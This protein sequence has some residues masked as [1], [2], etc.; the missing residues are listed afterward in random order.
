VHEG[1][2][3]EDIR[4]SVPWSTCPALGRGI[5]TTNGCGDADALQRSGHA[6]AG[7]PRLVIRQEHIARMQ[8]TMVDVR[9]RRQ[10]ERSRQLHRYAK[11]ISGRRRA[12]LTNRQVQRFGRDVILCEVRRHARDTGRQWDR[13]CGVIQ[14]GGDELIE[15]GNELMDAFGRQIQFEELDRNQSFA[16]RVI[17]AEYRP[18]RAC[19]NLMENPK[20]SEGFWSR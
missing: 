14:V 16:P 20:R 11:R 2:Q 12:V 7:Q 4:L 6:N 13:D 10:V 17:S 9:H 8:R 3:A 15:L 19:T 5:R 1:R 18:K